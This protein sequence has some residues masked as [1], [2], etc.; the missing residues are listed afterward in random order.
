MSV[1]E[2]LEVLKQTYVDEDQFGRL[3]DKLMAM[4]L[5]QHRVR[6]TR[7]NQELTQFE[8]KFKI[9][10]EMFYQRFQTGELGDSI[11]F[12]EW[13]GLYELRQDLMQKAAQ[14]E[15]QR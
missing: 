4:I 7:Y 1:H 14:L 11:D 9:D 13:A 10:S 3:L 6:L 5:T 12:F 15:L 8:Q 2:K